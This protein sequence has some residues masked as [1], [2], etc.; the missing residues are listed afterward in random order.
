M[1]RG[2]YRYLCV[3]LL[4][5]SGFQPQLKSAIEI[6]TMQLTTSDGLVNNSVSCTYQDSKGFIWIGTQNGL[7]RYD[8]NSF[9]AFRPRKSNPFLTDHVIT[10]IVEDSNEFLW[11]KTLSNTYS[12]YDLKKD[13]FVDFT[14]CGEY[15]NEYK[16]ISLQENGDVWL[17]GDQMGCRMNSYKNNSFTSVA[18]NTS[19]GLLSN[20]ITSLKKGAEGWI[21]IAT[22]QGLYYWDHSALHCVDKNTSF[23]EIQCWQDRTFFLSS[24]GCIFSFE[25]SEG[26]KQIAG[27]ANRSDFTL[28]GTFALS[29]KWI[30]YTG[31]GGYSFH[32]Q[33]AKLEPVE[34]NYDIA[35]TAIVQDNKS[36]Y[37]LKDR[38][39]KLYYVRSETGEVKKIQIL[40]AQNV[41][42]EQMRYNIHHDSRDIIWIATYGNGLYTYDLNTEE[43]SH[44]VAD[45]KYTDTP[46][47]S[48]FLQSVMED[49]LGNIWVGADYM[50]ATCLKIISEG[51]VRIFPSDETYIDYANTVRMVHQL[52]GGNIVIGTRNGECYEYDKELTA[53]RPKKILA[54][55]AYDM[56][57]DS[58]GNRWYAYR[59]NGLKVGDKVYTHNAADPT[60]LSINQIFCLCKSRKN[61]IWIGTFGG[62][63]NLAVPDKNGYTFRH[64]FNNSYGQKRIK[65]IKE[66]RNGWIWLGTNDGVF[67]FNPEELLKNPA[68]FYHYNFDKGDL[69]SNGIR[70]IMEDS[71]GRMWI[72][73]SGAGFSM[74]MPQADYGNLEFTHY[75]A[76]NGL[77]NNVVQAFVEDLNG[78]IWISTEYGISRFDPEAKM[79]ENYF[80]SSN[81][82]GNVYSET[83]GIRL[84][85]GR[86]VFGTYYGFTVIDPQVIKRNYY[87][88][89]VAFTN[90]Q[91][92]GLSVRAD[93]PE[94][95]LKLAVSYLS[96][97]MLKYNQNSFVLGF[98]IFDYMEN[99][100]VKYAYKLENYDNDWSAPSSMSFASYRNLPPGK[101]NLQV[102]ACDASGVW[103][104]TNM[105]ITIL[106]P[107]WKTWWAYLIYFVVIAGI[108]FIIF[109]TVRNMSALRNKVEIEKQ[110]TEYKLA[111][112]T[113]ISHEFRTPLTLIQG[114]LERMNSTGKISREI[115]PSVEVMDK[116][117]KRLL[118]LIN[119]LLEFR[120]V[121]KNKLALSLE[122]TDVIAFL[123]EIFLSFKDTAKSTNMDFR[124]ISSIPAYKMF[125]DK[126]CVDKITYNLLS[127]AFKYTNPGKKI[128]FVITLDEATRTMQM[129]VSDTGIGVPREKQKELFNRFM[130]SSFSADS[131]GVG[132]HLTRELVNLH[133]GGIWYEENPEGGS[134]FIVTFSTDPSVYKEEDFLMSNN[135]LSEEETSAEKR[136]DEVVLNDDNLNEEG[137]TLIEPPLSKFK[138][139]I[140]ED[141]NDVREF[142]KT[143]LRAYFE[144]E[145]ASDG[146]EGLVLARANEFDL[147][148]SDVLMPRCTG[149]ELT[150]RLKNDFDT[151]HIPIILLTALDT[152]DNHL[153]GI[154]YGADAYITKPFSTK[155]LITRAIK[156]LEQRERLRKKFSGD[157]YSTQIAVCTSDKDKLFVKRMEHVV[158]SQLANPEFTI[159]EFASIMG[160]GRSVFFRKVRGLIGCA[161]SEY[162]R[163]MRMKKAVELLQQGNQN[164]SEVSYQVGIDDPTYFTR[165][166]KKQFG[167]TPSA[168]QK[169]DANGSSNADN[170]EEISFE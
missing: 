71:K 94:S 131:V 139:L 143:E 47:G 154:K 61:Q 123:Y 64:F 66:D 75:D 112:F 90:F 8:G 98:S 44:Y 138:V 25:P 115:K 51:A 2:L 79:F 24:N 147:I 127:N 160:L 146:E 159:D 144:I 106:P 89:S 14:G 34:A 100:L 117:V 54:D 104:S 70:Y 46:I 31:K 121:Q 48:N 82:P 27:S 149:F 30:I 124:F 103:S 22:T 19:T 73:E 135:A 132:L 153:K 11:I 113:N 99:D 136:L 168:F 38:T 87:Q 93:D 116:S 81:M 122:E 45:K 150:K 33:T 126:D 43:I 63:L 17:W 59:N 96:E 140:V 88:T 80:F 68:A 165:C 67:I 3:F 41:F 125:I 69:Q 40:S 60:S 120:K 145:A 16:F 151:S 152:T 91:L 76:S 9:V 65:V 85:D 148:I 169:G 133:K 5:I 92:N 102:K 15:M 108:L 142:L 110:L 29:N 105:K 57:E 13:C 37:W 72:S 1:N 119:Q 56:I 50:G 158:N 137:D 107:F 118:R 95:P 7:S 26:L 128:E 55:N 58:T 166:F 78:M 130:Q 4:L 35:V 39:G 10:S 155:L 114:A 21:W 167:I 18:F 156:L 42:W 157:P 162:I 164:I 23:L 129:K 77:V 86:I 6:R 32:F 53:L 161:P 84:Y 97:I 12:C 74:C 28:A 52:K 163:I 49:R 83:C 36:N 20:N 101:Y 109:R 170:K 62:G 111:F 141:D 134:I